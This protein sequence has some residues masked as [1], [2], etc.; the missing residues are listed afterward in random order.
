MCEQ[1]EEGGRISFV[2]KIL[3]VANE[4]EIKAAL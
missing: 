2:T 3:K 1:G 4:V